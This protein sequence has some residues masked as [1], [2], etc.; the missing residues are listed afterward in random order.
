MHKIK[1]NLLFS[2]EFPFYINRVIHSSGKPMLLHRHEFIELVY[3]W[4]GSA[5]HSVNGKRSRLHK[6]DVFILSQNMKHRLTT[7]AHESMEIINCLFLPSLIKPDFSSLRDVKGFIEFSYIQPFF[8]PNKHR[9]RLAG[10]EDSDQG[11]V[12]RTA[13]SSEQKL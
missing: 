5:T 9:L 7:T 11:Q 8:H 12:G 3:V 6:G 13:C 2:S 4:K 10:M 1:K